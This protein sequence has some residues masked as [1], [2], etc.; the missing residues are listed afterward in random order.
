MRHTRLRGTIAKTTYVI[1]NFLYGIRRKIHPFLRS[2]WAKS[3]LIKQRR[4]LRRRA[5][6]GYPS[7]Y[8]Q[9]RALHIK[10]NGNEIICGYIFVLVR[11]EWWLNCKYKMLVRVIVRKIRCISFIR[12][13]I[14]WHH[15]L[16]KLMSSRYFSKSIA[17]CY[18]M[19]RLPSFARLHHI[20][21]AVFGG[22]AKHQFVTAVLMVY[23]AFQMR[24]WD[25][26]GGLDS[27]VKNMIT[28]LRAVSELQNPAIRDRHWQQLMQAT[29][30]PFDWC[31]KD[32][33]LSMWPKPVFVLRVWL[34]QSC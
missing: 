5:R 27:L 26:F 33:K 8:L 15:Q 10:I 16:F 34:Q 23:F 31:V 12:D 4:R 28:S 29:K 22:A 19:R 21:S 13:K 9:M 18:L 32:L 6:D 7:L 14:F 25:S 3:P 11:W 2:C 17:M 20:N 1:I 24:A 30:V